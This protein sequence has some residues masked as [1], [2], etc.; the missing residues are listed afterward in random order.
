MDTSVKHV[1]T[2]LENGP[3]EFE[4]QRL[5]QGKELLEQQVT[6]LQEEL[7]ARSRTLLS[8]QADF[9]E[10]SGQAAAQLEEAK[11]EAAEQR[12]R[13]QAEHERALTSESHAE[14][15]A[16]QLADAL[17]Q[18]VSLRSHPIVSLTVFS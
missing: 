4:V 12:Q 6:D 7:N 1:L 15:L 11:T 5:R 8:L 16:L 13:A 2:Q 10:K 14:R 9:G 17:K 3:L 18:A